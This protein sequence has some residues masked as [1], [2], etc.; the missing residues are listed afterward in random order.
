MVYNNGF[1]VKIITNTDQDKLKRDDYNYVALRNNTEYK[2]Q[3]IN[4][5]DTDAMAE[6][7]IENDQIGIWFIPSRGNVIIDRPANISRKFTFF[8][9][10]DSRARSAGVISGDSNNGLIKVIFYPKKQLY[11]NM[12]TAS[13]NSP[14]ISSNIPRSP[15]SPRSSMSFPSVAPTLANAPYMS[16]NIARSPRSSMSFPSVA[17]TLASAPSLTPLMN[18]E[19]SLSSYNQENFAPSTQY[20]SGATILGRESYQSF[21][22][23]RRFSNDEIDWSN[24]TEIILRL[25]IKP[26]SFISTVQSYSPGQWNKEFISVNSSR[27]MSSIPPRIDYNPVM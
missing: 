3:L 18:N 1:G 23:M 10:T 25:V 15:R 7:F 26:D 11:L 9:E 20:Q 27:G 17:P 2:L 13:R 24:K 19:R 12:S 6:V 8:R 21:G 14:Y 22:S 4:D 16:S 5:R